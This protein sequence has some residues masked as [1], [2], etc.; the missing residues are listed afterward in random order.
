MTNGLLLVISG[1]RDF[2]TRGQL[3]T[4]KQTRTDVVSMS[5]MGQKLINIA[6]NLPA[7]QGEGVRAIGQ[8]ENLR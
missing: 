4:Q 3:Y 2:A 6:K 1:R 5:A 7:E 8:A